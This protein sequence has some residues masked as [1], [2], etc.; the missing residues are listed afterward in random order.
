MGMDRSA[1]RVP[2]RESRIVTNAHGNCQ[3]RS[4][5]FAQLLMIPWNHFLSPV[6]VR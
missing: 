4:T 1:Y 2:H 3:I 5:L 6:T